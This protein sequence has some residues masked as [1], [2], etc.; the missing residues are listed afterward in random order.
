ML[1]LGLVLVVAYLTAVDCL[2][3]LCRAEDK[4]LFELAAS[5]LNRTAGHL[6]RPARKVILDAFK[7][8]QGGAACRDQEVDRKSGC[9]CQCLR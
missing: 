4:E 3:L 6:Q 5:A 9:Q 7:Q 2:R 8:V 1:I